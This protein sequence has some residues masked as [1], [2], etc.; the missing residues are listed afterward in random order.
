VPLGSLEA[1]GLRSGDPQVGLPAGHQGLRVLIGPEGRQSGWS[2]AVALYWRLALAFGRAKS[3]AWHPSV[4]NSFQVLRNGGPGSSAPRAPRA[5]PASPSRSLRRPS[6]VGGASTGVEL[7]A[8][9]SLL[10]RRYSPSSCCG[11]RDGRWLS[12][13]GP[14]AA[15][16]V[17]RLG[18]KKR[19]TKWVCTRASVDCATRRNR[20]P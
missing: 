14:S 4:R 11:P 17:V 2:L 7:P 18:L 15:R 5:V 12:S 3:A 9:S 8:R 16:S 6:A 20:V 19:R 13:V 10:R 1:G